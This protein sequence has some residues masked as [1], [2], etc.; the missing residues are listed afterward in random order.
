MMQYEVLSAT[1]EV[2]LQ[3]KIN[4]NIIKILELTFTLQEIWGTDELFRN[5]HRHAG[6][7]SQNMKWSVDNLYPISS[8]KFIVL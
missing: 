6:S 7:Q 3:N 1:Q 2:F 5:N 8:K 4:S